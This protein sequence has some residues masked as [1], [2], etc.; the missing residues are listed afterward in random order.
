MSETLEGKV[1]IVTGAGG[2]IGRET[3]KAMIE[4]GARVVV[5]DISEDH[6]RETVDYVGG[7]HDVQ[8]VKTDVSDLA[9]VRH[10]VQQTVETYGRLDIAHNNAGVEL[11]GPDLADTTEEQFQRLIRVNFTGVF[12]CLK[13]EIPQMLKQGGGSIINTSSSFG[14]V[15]AAGQSAYIASKHAVLGLTKSAAVEYSGRGVRVNAVL[16]GLIQTPLVEG[17]EARQ[18]GF[19]DQVV[20]QHP[21]GRIGQ[22]RDVANTVVWLA[23]DLSS[24]ITGASIAVDGGRLAH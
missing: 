6:G 16:P 4:N 12:F 11:A 5:A 10:L 2:G 24:F 9:S 23:S 3:V 7:G 18:P 21:I 19:I 22:P 13:V 8:F 17:I 14:V 20:E 1:A 15:A